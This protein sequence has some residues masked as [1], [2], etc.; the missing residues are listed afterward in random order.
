MRETFLLH[1]K[2]DIKY[3]TERGVSKISRIG[4][5]RKN[6]QKFRKSESRRSYIYLWCRFSS[7]ASPPSQEY[8][9][10]YSFVSCPS[11]E[12][13]SSL[14]LAADPKCVSHSSAGQL[15]PQLDNSHLLKKLIDFGPACD[16]WQFER[17]NNQGHL[18]CRDSS[19]KV[20]LAQ[21]L[22]FTTILY[23]LFCKI[24]ES[25]VPGHHV[26]TF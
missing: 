11:P 5:M 16:N 17:V 22:D 26:P 3:D 24:K 10:F 14:C 25:F 20:S 4:K 12:Y 15:P 7:S 8:F 18:K 9:G 6:Q 2:E 23:L 1:T 21:V 19:D 13:T